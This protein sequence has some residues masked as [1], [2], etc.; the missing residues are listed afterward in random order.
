MKRDEG[1]RTESDWVS[2]VQ[3][4][5][6]L[7]ED[8]E[9]VR[10][11]MVQVN[12][13]RGN[14][15]IYWQPTEKK[16]A[17][18][19]PDEGQERITFNVI[20]P[21]VMAKLAKQTKNRIKFDVVPDS[22]DQ[23]RIEIAKAAG[24][25]LDYWW[26]T[27][28]LDRKTRDIFL[29]NGVKGWCALKVYFD[30]MAGQDITPQEGET[31][32]EEGMEAL[33]TGEVKARVCDPLSIYVDP[34]ATTD[35]EIRW[36][37]ERK[38]RDVDY[39]KDV[40]GKEVTADESVEYIQSYE[41]GTASSGI[42]TTNKQ[43][44]MS[45]MA[46]VD[47]MWVAPC[48]KHPR[49]LKVT[50]AGSVLLDI[51]EKA[52][53]IPFF[54]FGDIPIP[55][56]VKY[57]A[58]I[59]D[60]LPVQKQINI[61][62]TM[63]ATHAKRMGNSFW[64]V[65]HGTD[66]DEDELVNEIGAVLYYNSQTG[67]PQR[68]SPPDL[69]SFYDRALEYSLRD[70]D[71]M[72][73][74]RE[75]TQG[76]LPAGLDTLGGLELMVEQENEKLAVSSQNYERGMKRA[77]NRVLELMKKHYTEERL[78]RILGKDNEIELIAFTG[79]DLSGGEDINIVQGS[80]LPEMRAA[81]QERIMTMWGAGAIVDDNGQ[82]D[83]RKLL[84]LMGMGDSQELFEQRRLDENKA[85]SENRIF[86]QMGQDPSIE[87]TLAQ[88]YTQME[89]YNAINEQAQAQGVDPTT[90][91]LQTPQLPQGLPIVR[92]FYDHVVHIDEHN[93]F[94]KS[95]E[96]EQLP[97]NVQRFIDEHV[98]EHISALE[99]PMQAQ[100]QAEQQAAEQQA[101]QQQAAQEEQMALRQADQA[102]QT[103]RQEMDMQ[104]HND[105]MQL[106]AGKLGVEVMKAMQGRG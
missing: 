105:N 8:W 98:Q 76:R 101:A 77:L 55:G 69:P 86:T 18:A 11:I 80:S 39:I 75:I 94:R 87:Q 46:M 71:D 66:V 50:V 60:M 40:Y 1:K 57:D 36:I 16:V 22:N 83:H 9:S 53:P 19:P 43:R 5:V 72:S 34:S 59:R 64:A 102:R 25:F 38:P 93:T 52:G 89:Q 27:E 99:A 12:Y 88:F 70:I 31:G 104:K 100:Q 15:W 32:Y 2:L 37:V 79:S 14:Q 23:E 96:Y 44:K 6:K 73:G 10:Q 20:K 45:N 95:S 63:M 68:I 28:E 74:A 58:F 33:Y 82:P 91:G 51:D 67:Q 21:R 13:Y 106:Q 41:I 42:G 49:G 78:G 26:E 29:N 61:I 65:P 3:E 92:D 7:A 17:L 24:R 97:P 103:A 47:E 54:I 56:S 90:L 4:R 85:R 84:R 35:D 81:Q 48:K 62:R 30:P